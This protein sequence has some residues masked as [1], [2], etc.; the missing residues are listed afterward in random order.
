MSIR[1]KG[2][3][4]PGT[5]ASSRDSVRRK[6]RI[7]VLLL[8]GCA[9]FLL[10]L[11][12]PLRNAWKS[13]LLVVPI[14]VMAIR[15]TAVLPDEARTQPPVD[16]A[17]I[18]VAV[19][20]LLFMQSS[21][22]S[23]W[24]YHGRAAMAAALLGMS[25]Q[26]LLSLL[27]TILAAGSLP[28]VFCAC[29]QIL[30]MPEQ[31]A[32][33]CRY[34]RKDYIAA[35]LVLL[36]V[37]LVAGA[38]VTRGMPSLWG[39]D[40]S[41]YIATGKAISEGTFAEQ[42]LRSYYMHPT[43]L[44]AEAGEGK[45]VY[46]WG[47]PLL[48]SF[49]HRFVGWDM[50]NFSSVIFYKI[51]SVIALA[52]A[53]GAL[54]LFYRRYFPLGLS[55][56]LALIFA[57]GGDQFS[58]INTMY[59]DTVYLGV[60]VVTLWAAECFRDQ[61]FQKDRG[62]K[63]V[64]FS[65]GL[66]FLFWLTYEVR[67]NGSTLILVA[68]IGHGI[69]LIQEKPRL[70]RKEVALHLS[71]Y[72]TFFAMKA[73]SEWILLPATSNA[74]DIGGLSL[75]I[76]WG[77]MT[78]YFRLTGEYLNGLPGLAGVPLWPV[79]YVLLAIGFFA[80]GFKIKNIHLT[81]LLMGTYVVLIL[82]PYTQGIR[83]LSSVLPILLLYTAYG[84]VYILRWAMKGIPAVKL[85]KALACCAALTCL[86]SVYIPQVRIG[87][88]NIR[89]GRQVQSADVYAE[90]A[91]ELYRFIQEYTPEDAVIAFF[92]P[93]ILS[94]NTGRLCFLPGVNGHVLEDA[95][96]YLYAKPVHD[97]L[98]QEILKNPRLMLCFESPRFAFYKIDKS[99]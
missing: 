31:K 57:A 58:F 49:I 29:R 95:D 24:L 92:K 72:I 76:I 66:G 88:E 89:S 83:Y 12:H 69:R 75:Q 70:T 11:S 91:I 74:S 67:L 54:Y 56:F 33:I 17:G 78:Y 86:L 5:F 59:S 99:N 3:A 80:E 14:L 20:A 77:N 55:V 22:C 65:V 98:D 23:R 2:E 93:R 18:A 19:L 79:L 27:G 85:W 8:S 25:T 61:L 10:C 64:L 1:R 42:S 73:I 87:A 94:L 21:F 26:Q 36:S 9:L 45:L 71:A 52:A 40:F 13:L 34:D 7:P 28:L 47:Y 16:F 15:G 84:A 68:A 51:P 81:S 38:Q 30:R 4:A 96:Y 60:S 32:E 48:L 90:D 41:A 37:F 97:D 43:P 39:G 53:A 63:T 50:V 62:R 46:A 6:L 82:L 44:P 35:V